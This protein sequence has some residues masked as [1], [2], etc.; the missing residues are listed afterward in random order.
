MQELMPWCAKFEPEDYAKLACDFKVDVLKH[1]APLYNLHGVQGVIFE[2]N[3]RAKLTAA[4]LGMQQRLAQEDTSSQNIAHDASLLTQT[5]LFT[6]TAD[7]LMEW[8][9][10]LAEHEPLRPSIAWTP[11]LMLFPYLLP[12]SI[13][14]LARQK[15]QALPLPSSD[16]QTTAKDGTRTWSEQEYWCALYAYGTQIDEDAVTVAVEELKRR[17][18]DS[19]EAFH[20]LQL[21]RREPQYFGK[22]VLGDEKIQ[23]HLFGQHRWSFIMPIYSEKDDVPSYEELTSMLPIEVVGSFLASPNRQNDLSRWGQALMKEACAV[24]Q[25]TKGSPDKVEKTRSVVNRDVLRLWAEQNTTDFLEL[26]AQFL[27]GLLRAPCYETVLR[28][29]TDDVLCLLL[30]FR[31]ETAREYYHHWNAKAVWGSYRPDSTF[32]FQLWRVKEC[33]LP[34]HRQFRRSLLEETPNDYHIMC[35]TLAALAEGGGDELW[36][37]ATQE[38]LASSTAKER[39]LGVSILP[40]FGNKAAIAL[41]K[42]LQSEDPSHW[43][44]RHAKWAYEVVQQ[45]QSC[46]AVYREAL[47]TRDLLRISAV[48]EPLKPALSPIALWWHHL[49]EEEELGDFTSDSDAKLH[50]LL[51]QFWYRWSNSLKSNPHRD[52][53]DRRLRDYC[54]GDELQGS[55]QPKIAPWWAPR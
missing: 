19:K 48:L 17:E 13:V 55:I 40:W 26:A 20:L 21:A 1:N 3:D 2:P 45:E 35:M 9:E 43:V 41:L 11:F 49:I 28:S 42:R 24:L 32:L 36:Q 23:Q 33:N 25:G 54:R 44:R 18:P 29:L 5:L 53:F 22:Q 10:F 16:A 34:A 50:A 27:K 14:K 7:E 38:Y 46:R 4:I 52:V 30:R 8:F 31:P 39:N 12:E 47:Q 6:A 15:V 51:Y 37:L